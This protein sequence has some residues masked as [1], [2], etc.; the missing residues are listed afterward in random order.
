MDKTNSTIWLIISLCLVLVGVAFV[1][2]YGKYSSQKTTLIKANEDLQKK[3]I[4]LEKENKL[5][6]QKPVLVSSPSA[7]PK[8]GGNL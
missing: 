1:W 3:I 2:G 6:M 5:L 4:E 7:S 8:R